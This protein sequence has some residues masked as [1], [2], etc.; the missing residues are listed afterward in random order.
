MSLRALQPAPASNRSRRPPTKAEAARELLARR[1]AR[2]HMAGYIEYLDI[3]ITPAKHH[4]ALIEY[5]EA[6]ERGD[7]PRL[8]IFLPPGSAKALALD[9]P[10]PTADGWKMMGELRVGDRVF[11][12][13]GNL[14]NVT[15]VSEIWNNRPVFRV[16]TDCGD[17][18]VADADHEWLVRLCGKPRK[19]LI[20][21]KLGRKGLTDRDNPMSQFKIKETW[22]LCR[23]RSKRPMIMHC[24][25]LSTPTANL[26]ID[27]YLLGLWLGDGNSTGVRIT[28]SDEDRPW[29]IGELN[30]I[31]YST[32]H[33][34][35]AQHF[36]VLGVRKEF[37]R[38]G[39]INDPAHSTY[40][41]KHI[42][43]IYM[44]AG[45]EQRLSLLQGLI[46]SDGTVCK[47]RGCT[48]FCNTNQDLAAG[49]QEIAR[50]L[51]VKA[52]LIENRAMLYGKD[53]G[54]AYRVSFY[55]KNSAR[56]PRK[57]ILTRNQKRTQ[58][59]YIDVE[60]AGRADTVCISVDSDSHLF[61]CGRSMTPTHN[62]T[63][64][65]MIFP[66]WY[67]GK[68]PKKMSLPRAIRQNSLSDSD[69]ACVDCIPRANISGF[70]TPVFRKNPPPLGVGALALAVSISRQAR[71]LVLPVFAPISVLSTIRSAIVKTPTRRRCE[72][73]SGTGTRPISSLD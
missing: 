32:S 65:S 33:K 16:I 47:K 22:E 72:I 50:S 38:L 14:C 4:L 25:A 52:G 59:T 13:N 55:L 27:P 21:S 46:D 60:E 30:R 34:E 28:S 41:R 35:G 42:P 73:K 37:V 63:Y 70:S 31:G 6:V 71:A 1:G 39:L 11:D 61:L 29:I 58:N 56:L 48:T 40:G 68:H 43:N 67:L 19:P 20:G 36:G 62:S 57:K 69:G 15:R 3:G 17:E 23:K 2:A 49:V 54:P 7:I 51:G 18:I 45:I 24:K 5:L 9:T 44:R 8:M 66:A 53:C 12:E 26:P 10:I 64:A